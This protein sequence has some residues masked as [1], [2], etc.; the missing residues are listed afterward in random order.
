MSKSGVSSPAVGE[1]KPKKKGPRLHNCLICSIPLSP[2]VWKRYRRVSL[3]LP[4]TPV[5]QL[6]LLR[7]FG[8]RA[9]LEEGVE[10]DDLNVMGLSCC[11]SCSNC[12]TQLTEVECQMS[13]FEKRSEELVA[14]LKSKMKLTVVVLG[15]LNGQSFAR[16]EIHVILIFRCEVG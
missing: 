12:V 3:K 5:Q 13:E 15:E 9:D 8:V 16:V 11:S 4:L 14:I 10:E 7:S 1:D 6:N 2:Y